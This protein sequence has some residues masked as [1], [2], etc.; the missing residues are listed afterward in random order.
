[1]AKNAPVAFDVSVLK[2]DAIRV[3][4]AAWF[5][6]FR[7]GDVVI[8]RLT[9]HEAKPEGSNDSGK[10]YGIAAD[11]TQFQC[12]ASAIVDNALTSI[13]P[14]TVVLV[15]FE[16]KVKHPSKAGKT[17]NKFGVYVLGESFPPNCPSPDFE[18]IAAAIQEAK[19]KKE[20][21]PF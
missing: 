5:S 14:G 6:F 10:F 21:L 13:N 12:F 2:K 1:M 15:E 9:R 16:G 18:A 4:S 3:D 20:E 7:P 8:F 11:G 17:L 19:D